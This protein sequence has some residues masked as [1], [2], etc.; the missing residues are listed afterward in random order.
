MLAISD[1]KMLEF[2]IWSGF[3]STVAE[4]VCEVEESLAGLWHP[5][6]VYI[7]SAQVDVLT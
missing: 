4:A 6:D 2:E 7:Q 5:A 1:T 3:R